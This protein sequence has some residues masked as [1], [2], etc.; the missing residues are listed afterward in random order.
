MLLA[1]YYTRTA[2]T[3]S[4]DELL[5]ALSSTERCALCLTRNRRDVAL[6]RL[7]CLRCE[8][9]RREALRAEM[10]AAINPVN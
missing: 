8:L 9:E 5:R 3:L 10:K 2:A 6:L 1:E 4:D 7:R